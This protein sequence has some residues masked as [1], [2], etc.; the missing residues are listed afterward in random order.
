MA[1]EMRCKKQL[2]R[3]I[4]ELRG[5]RQTLRKGFQNKLR[6]AIWNSCTKFVLFRAY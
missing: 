2:T 1:L 6:D 3:G 5:T 4:L